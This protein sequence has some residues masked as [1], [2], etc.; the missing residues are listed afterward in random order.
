MSKMT[1]AKLDLMTPKLSPAVAESRE[2]FATRN[3]L[4]Q[5][6][7]S[8]GNKIILDAGDVT[9]GGRWYHAACWQLEGLDSH[10]NESFG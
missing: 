7:E 3:L 1:P 4:V 5:T 6:C 8:C 2:A 10:A 9:F